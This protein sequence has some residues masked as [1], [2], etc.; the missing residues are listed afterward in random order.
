MK[1]ESDAFE[2]RLFFIA[3]PPF[4]ISSLANYLPDRVQ[5][6]QRNNLYGS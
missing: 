4:S 2:N 1:D 6:L 3:H 5:F